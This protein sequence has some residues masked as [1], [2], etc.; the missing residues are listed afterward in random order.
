MS[1]EQQPKAQTEDNEK[2]FRPQKIYLKDVS[3][4]SPNS[5]ALFTKK[6][7]PK[8]S[9][10]I[11]HSVSMLEDSIYEVI[12]AVTATVSVEDKTAFLA[13]VHQAGI[14]VLKGYEPDEQE[15]LQQVHCLRTLYPYASAA[16]SDLVTKGGFPQLLLVPM[17]FAAVYAKKLQQASEQA[18]AADE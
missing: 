3:F 10:E 9:V 8:V 18:E 12:I 14:F 13:E 4:E 6:W 16:L 1:E 5:P 17:N 2:I 15:R 11:D 7:T